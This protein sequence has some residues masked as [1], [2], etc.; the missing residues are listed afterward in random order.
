MTSYPLASLS[1]SAS[2]RHWLLTSSCCLMLLPSIASSPTLLLLLVM[3]VVLLPCFKIN[4]ARLLQSNLS[5]T[6]NEWQKQQFLVEISSSNISQVPR[7]RISKSI[8]SFLQDD[9]STC[10]G[11][12]ATVYH[13]DVLNYFNSLICCF[14]FLISTFVPLTRFLISHTLSVS[15]RLRKIII[16]ICTASPAIMYM[17]SSKWALLGQGVCTVYYLTCT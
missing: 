9:A 12:C 15:L 14:F 11:V 6:I 13:C 4:L 2:W 17:L 8:L 16:L 7:L 1:H 3:V 5:Q 10:I